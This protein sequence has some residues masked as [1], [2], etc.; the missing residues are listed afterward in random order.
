[1]NTIVEEHP[2]KIGEHII[3]LKGNCSDP[4]SERDI[5]K[6]NLIPFEKQVE[7][8]KGTVNLKYHIYK[9]SSFLNIIT[10]DITLNFSSGK[11]KKV[12][13]ECYNLKGEPQPKTLTEKEALKDMEDQKEL[14]TL[15]K[16][17]KKRYLLF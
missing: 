17:K 12:T 13:V 7:K 9:N 1:M 6:G 8:Q 16:K 14:E 10:G 4:R 2:H 11:S 3:T 15:Q 5:L